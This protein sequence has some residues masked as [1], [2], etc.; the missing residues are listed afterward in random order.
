MSQNGKYAAAII[1]CGR[2]ASEFDDD[3]MMRRNYGIATHA[4]AYADN[5]QTNLVA[6]A[7]VMDEKL[8]KFGHRW[9][10]PNLY[11]DYEEMLKKEDI[12]ILSIC[13]PNATHL[14]IFEKAVKA[15]VKAIFCEKPLADSLR[16]ADRMVATARKNGVTLL[17][18]HRRRWDQL[19]QDVADYL[20]T[21]GLG[22][23]EQVSC[24]YNA[25]IANTGCHL[26]DV[27]RMFFG[28]ANTVSAWRKDA[29]DKR[30]PNMDGYITFENNVSVSIQSL[31]I[32]NYLV[33]EFDIY[34][35]KGRLRIEHN[36]FKLSYWAPV[37]SERFAGLNELEPQEPP[38][39]IPE[40]AMFK[41]TVRDIVNCLQTKD[42]PACSGEDGVKALEIISAFHLS[43][44]N[45]GKAVSLPPS[46]REYVIESN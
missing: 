26:F 27:L 12:D 43:A 32:K 39:R 38:I 11:K 14:E 31:D 5:P 18:N 17:V 10:V 7:D 19:Y 22:N 21:G 9:N 40:P 37:K 15:G 46:N 2:I 13:T 20:R 4:G 45:D 30:D 1:G 29:A 28:E 42:Q 44:K 34:G 41:N 16:S 6:A 35:S 3:P 8:S 33:F 25:G 36:G 23:I 24:Y